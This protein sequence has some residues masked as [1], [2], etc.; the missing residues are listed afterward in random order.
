MRKVDIEPL[1]IEVVKSLVNDEYFAKEIES[2]IG[3]QIDTQKIDRE[4]TNC[5]KKSKEVN[6]NK[7]RLENEIDNLPVDA[8]YRERK[9]SDCSITI[10]ST[11]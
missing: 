10:T 1:V 6:I 4:I 3:V 8:K 5:Q 9:I 11:N 2:R 7:T